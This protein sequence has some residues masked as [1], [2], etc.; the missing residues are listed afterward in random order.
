MENRQVHISEA[1]T[2]KCWTVINYKNNW[3]LIKS[4][5][6]EWVINEPLQHQF[7]IA[8]NQAI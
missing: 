2:S 7:I 1:K 6:F 4:F 8:N 5:S 3:Q